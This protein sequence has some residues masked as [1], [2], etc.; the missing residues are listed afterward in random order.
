MFANKIIL[1]IYGTQYAN[2]V[3]ALKILIWAFF[4]ICVST[5]TSGLLNS[6]NKQRIVTIGTGI[7]A[8]LNIILNLILIPKYSLDGAASATVAIELFGFLFYFYFA[9]KYLNLIRSDI[10]LLVTLRTEMSYISKELRK[11]WSKRHL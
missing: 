2:S 6:I 3:L 11:I 1:I 8:L 7:G 9:S 10:F 5:V 4:L